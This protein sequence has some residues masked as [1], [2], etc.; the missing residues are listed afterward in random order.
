MLIVLPYE[1]GVRIFY[2]SVNC[3]IVYDFAWFI[4]FNDKNDI[5]VINK[6]N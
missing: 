1:K 2:S 6:I 3:Y 4:I 5:L